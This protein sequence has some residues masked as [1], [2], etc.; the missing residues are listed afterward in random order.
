M[1]DQPFPGMGPE[2]KGST[3]RDK[4]DRHKAHVRKKHKAVKK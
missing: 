2:S 4:G 3:G 1:Q